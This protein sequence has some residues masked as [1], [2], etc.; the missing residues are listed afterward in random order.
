MLPYPSWLNP[1]DNAWQL[2]AATL[3][4]LMSLP[5]IAILYGGLVQRKWAVNTMLMA[6]SGFSLVLLA[7]VLW[8]Y[9]MGFGSPLKLG[10]GILGAFVGIPG[11]VIGH[12]GEQGQAHIP[13]LDGAMPKFRFP[14][15]TLVYFQFVFAAITPLLF[16]G[17]VVGRVNF[18]VWLLFVPLWSTLAY[19]V[20]AFLLWG[21]GWWAQQ[22]ALD[23]SGGYVIHLAAGTTG[24][25]A[26]AVIG[27]RLAR[28]R[29]RATP[30]NLLL[31]AAGAGILWLGWNGFNGGDPYFSGADAVAA[32]LNTN[33]AT[34]TALLGWLVLDLFAGPQRKPTFLG[35]INGMIS[36]LVAITPAAGYVNG[37]GAILIG[38]IA[39]VFVWLSWNKLAKLSLFKRVDDALG[40][41]HTHGVAGLTGGLLVGL[42]ADP[43]MIVY[44]GQGKTA[45]FS[46]AGLFYGNPKQLAVQ[47]GAALTV[48]VWDALITFLILRFLGLFLKLRMPDELLETGDLAVHD[49]EGYP[50][51]ALVSSGAAGIPAETP[52]ADR[53]PAADH[54]DRPA[55]PA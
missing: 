14:Q 2:T 48:I 20:N 17:S 34:A 54:G 9:K 53:E 16:L 19:S 31:V 50:T 45:G 28:D 52:A 12:L 25:T 39:T 37:L 42:F 13:L 35:A 26:A 55:G 23:Y 22:G 38:L 46:A 47:A 33:L 5:G 43:H 36:G 18:R 6:F 3:V 30:N 44:L 15:A 51:E 49:E 8:V 41:F 10:P 27:P 4:G 32:V 29:A 7:W 21:G 40:V 24:F 11:A 1:G